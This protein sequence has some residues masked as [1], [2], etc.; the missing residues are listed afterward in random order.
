MSAPRLRSPPAAAKTVPP[1]ASGPIPCAEICCVRLMSSADDSSMSPPSPS[2]AP[3]AALICAS[4]WRLPPADTL[5]SPPKPPKSG[6]PEP[7]AAMRPPT[8]M[9]PFALSTRKPPSLPAPLPLT[10][11]LALV[12]RLPPASRSIEPPLRPPDEST[13]GPLA[14]I[15]PPADT[16]RSPPSPSI[17][18]S[19]CTSPAS[20]T[21][22][23]ALMQIEPASPGVPLTSRSPALF[24]LPPAVSVSC[25]PVVAAE[26]S[27]RARIGPLRSRRMS[28]VVSI[29]TLAPTPLAGAVQRRAPACRRT[30][31]ALMV[32]EF[33]SP[34][35][36]IPLGPIEKA[37][38]PKSSVD[39]GA[40][41]RLPEKTHGT[42]GSGSSQGMSAAVVAP[43]RA[44]ASR[45]AARR[46]RAGQVRRIAPGR[47]QQRPYRDRAPARHA[48][49][50]RKR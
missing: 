28:P 21:A 33:P 20:V 23:T 7:S 43:T 5:T 13:S 48:K 41:V 26:R 3:P 14:A 4:S 42:V 24:T 38:V 12:E 39:P 30:A 22:P 10:S 2:G 15:A 44:D 36:R 18:A 50:E 31:G 40:T 45:A 47:P 1:N 17:P 29:V 11:S 9:A 37:R 34:A 27:I 35:V 19:R 25:P 49:P 8:V 46:T 16:V 6:D 32:S